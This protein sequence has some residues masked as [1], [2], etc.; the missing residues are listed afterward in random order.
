[1]P[2]RMEGGRDTPNMMDFSKSAISPDKVR[3]LRAEGY[4]DEQIQAM[5]AEGSMT[6][7]ELYNVGE[8]A[9]IFKGR[10]SYPLI[11]ESIT[12][13]AK[14]LL[15]NSD[16]AKYGFG[17]KRNEGSNQSLIGA[18]MGAARYLKEKMQSADKSDLS[19]GIRQSQIVRDP[20]G[21]SNILSLI[22][23]GIE[24]PR[25][26]F[27]QVVDGFGEL[28]KEEGGID[29]LVAQVEN[30]RQSDFARDPF[31]VLG[32]LANR[33][34]NAYLGLEGDAI[35][36]VDK[37]GYAF[38]G[39]GGISKNKN[40][41]NDEVVSQE[42]NNE[43]VSQEQIEAARRRDKVEAL[44]NTP[45]ALQAD[46]ATGINAGNSP[47]GLEE[48]V[49][50]GDAGGVKVN[51][52]AASRMAQGLALAQLGAGIASGDL[53]KGI[54]DAST[55]FAAQTDRELDNARE[56]R[57]QK[58]LEKY[59]GRKNINAL[60]FEDA[61]DIVLKQNEDPITGELRDGVT[62]ADLVMQANSLMQSQSSNKAQG[63][64]QQ[65]PASERYSITTP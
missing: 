14:D 24:V 21:S 18:P 50:A 57:N 17:Y 65:K 64:N 20:I 10:T 8:E 46:L 26:A 30:A 3:L 51:P 11:P 36:A 60:S 45:S 1:M 43:V 6:G 19:E 13:S 47:E 22:D 25:R 9:D 7:Q 39:L 37:L 53:G 27:N 41:G 33:G 40:T 16:I 4:S 35:N 55:M 54:S 59:Y 58:M 56:D 63:Y 12:E 31:G 62:S 15:D 5:I 28:T 29:N 52:R 44:K 61:Y 42:Q 23:R 38:S 34:K 48:M 2:Y 32:D 49:D